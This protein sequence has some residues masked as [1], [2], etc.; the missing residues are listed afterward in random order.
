V[1]DASLTTGVSMAA[2]SVAADPSLHSET[3]GSSAVNLRAGPSSNAQQIAVLQPGEPVQTGEISGGWVKV[4]R[5]DGTS[6]WVY[7]SYLSGGKRASSGTQ[8]ADTSTGSLAATPPPAPKAARPRAVVH[9]AS[10]DLED[11]IARIA[12]RLPGYARPSDSAQSVFT[13]TPGDEV[14]IAEVRGNWLRVETA[15]GFTAWIRR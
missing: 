1:Q 3:V 7:S 5:A 15:D 6:G 2:P 9:G 13:F 12:S 11:R 4:T 8:V 10:G 14:R